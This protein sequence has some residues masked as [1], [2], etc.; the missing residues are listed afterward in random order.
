[1]WIGRFT[2]F[3]AVLAQCGVGHP[4]H[5]TAQTGSYRLRCEQVESF[6]PSMAFASDCIFYWR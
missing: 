5:F 2:R 4:T 1:M 6:F 3:R